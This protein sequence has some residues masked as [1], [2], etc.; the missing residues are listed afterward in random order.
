MRRVL[1]VALGCLTA[2]RATSSAVE[3]S[4]SSLCAPMERPLFSCTSG[5]K[6]ISVCAS[7][8][9]SGSSGYLKYKFGR[10]Q[11]KIE[12]SYP[13]EEAHPRRYFRFF[14]DYTSAKASSEQLSFV[15]GAFSY[16]VF[17]DRSAFDFNGSGVF[18]K[19]GGKPSAY[20]PCD[21]DHP[22]P[23]ELFKLDRMGLPS[24]PYD[25]IE[26]ELKTNH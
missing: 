25:S 10:S 21:Q 20:F 22:S 1:I 24:A 6:V 17:V 16:S 11:H 9:L 2:A 4:V 23:D 12:L 3:E 26:D 15:I 8:D 5:T 18:V 13:R 14:G 7:P 19:S